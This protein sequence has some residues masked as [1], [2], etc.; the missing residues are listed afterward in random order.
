MF[1]KLTNPLLSPQTDRLNE[2]RQQNRELWIQ[3]FA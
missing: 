2:F 1:R 3:R